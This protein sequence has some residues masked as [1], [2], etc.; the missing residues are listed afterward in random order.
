MGCPC[1]FLAP[2]VGPSTIKS[3]WARIFFGAGL[4]LYSRT[5]PIQG[6][7]RGSGLVSKKGT[8]PVMGRKEPICWSRLDLSAPR[9]QAFCTMEEYQSRARALHLSLLLPMSCVSLV[10]RPKIAFTMAES[11]CC[12]LHGPAAITSGG[13]L[14][15]RYASRVFW[16]KRR[17]WK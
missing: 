17:R 3:H 2:L 9:W 6:L 15:F 4:M 14:R 11:T 8:L 12:K 1:S 10:P 16:Q 7:P 5:P 13:T